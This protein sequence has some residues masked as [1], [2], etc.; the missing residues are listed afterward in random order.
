M[1]PI[2]WMYYLRFMQLPRFCIGVA[3]L[4]ANYCLKRE[5]TSEKRNAYNVFVWKLEATKLLAR[6]VSKCESSK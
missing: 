6:H 3:H 4:H 2:A 5:V 1:Y